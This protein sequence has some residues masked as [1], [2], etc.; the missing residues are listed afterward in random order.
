MAW[1]YVT[2]GGGQAADE[3]EKSCEKYKM[4]PDDAH[5]FAREIDAVGS[6]R[7]CSAAA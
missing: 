5:T 3:N 2:L 1:L 6:G 7:S 4:V